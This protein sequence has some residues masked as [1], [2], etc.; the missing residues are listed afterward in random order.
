MIIDVFVDGSS[1]NNGMP[2]CRAGYGAYFPNAEYL[3]ISEKIDETKEKVSNNVGELLA[4]IKAIEK[5]QENLPDCRCIIIY[6]DSKLTI[7]SITE[8]CSG[9]EKNNW[10]KKDKK[11]VKNV[12]LVKKLY[13]YYKTNNIRFNHVRS[14][15][16]EPPNKCSHNY[17]LWYGN[18]MADLLAKK[19]VMD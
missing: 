18:K 2:N 19:K 1:I 12:E 6:T 14:H 4:C 10:V 7:D 17:Y 11:P 9:W 3:N 15:Q 16:S 5:I 8:W 13:T